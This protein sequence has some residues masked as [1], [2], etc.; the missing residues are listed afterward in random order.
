MFLLLFATLLLP[1][2]VSATDISSCWQ[3]NESGEYALTQNISGAI[4]ATASLV[5]SACIVIASDDIT[6]DCNGFSITN[7]GTED[8]AGILVN[9]STTIHY[10][11]VTIQNCPS[12]SQYE[13]G[14]YLYRTTQNI[15]RNTTT[16]NNTEYG[17]QLYSST[18]SNLTNNTEYN[19]SR[20]IYLFSSDNNAITGNTE[21]N[22]S[23][24][25]YLYSGSSNTLTNNSAYNNSN[26]GIYLYIS[27]SNNLT[28]NTAY[29]NPKGVYLLN[30]KG[31][32][33]TNCTLYSNQYGL[34][35][36]NSNYTMETTLFLPSGGEMENY[37]NLS[38]TDI[39]EAGE[40]YSINWS[41]S[42]ETFPTD[43]NPFENKYLNITTVAGTP[44]INSIIW[45]WGESE[46]SGYNESGFQLWKYNESGWTLINGTPDTDANELTIYAMG[47]ASIY[48]IFQSDTTPPDIYLETPEEGYTSNSSSINFTFKATDTIDASFNC[49]LYIDSE[50][51]QSNSSTLNN[52][53]TTFALSSIGDGAHNWSITCLD[54]N[55]NSNSS[56]TRNFTVDTIPPTVSLSSP[57][58]I[59]YATNNFTVNYT[60]D[61]TACSMFLDGTFNESLAICENTTLSN[62]SEGQHYVT[63]YANDS[64]NNTGSDEVYF[65]V[66]LTAPSITLVSPANITYATN[67]ISVNYTTNGVSCSM[68]LDGIFNTTLSSCENTT[69]SNLTDGQ[70]Y[71]TIYAND[72]VNNTGSDEVYF[73]VD[74]IAP[75]VSIDYPEGGRIYASGTLA[76]NY[77]TDGSYCSMSINDV[78]IQFLPDCENVTSYVFADG[79]SCLVIEAN[80]SANNTKTAE[81]CI[82]VETGY[83]EGEGGGGGG[84]GG[85]TPIEEEEIIDLEPEPIELPK[86]GEYDLDL[87]FA[88]FDAWMREKEDGGISNGWIFIGF[89]GIVTW[90]NNP[91]EK[92]KGNA[93]GA[94][95]LVITIAV[96]AAYWGA[97]W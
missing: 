60:T 52:T 58:N 67:N 82:I 90:L 95:M 94:T 92:K 43:H 89:L 62:L 54:N 56:E 12:V 73:I 3:I 25:I 88:D 15:V 13:T 18:Y 64:V 41:E 42:P 77:V 61:G 26:H 8:A 19:N 24:G 75:T 44:S 51:N 6:F 33:I 30:S 14:V 66:D 7:N 96:L 70:H 36:E 97:L 81:R 35:A 1:S 38:I 78:F 71:V 4:P 34:Y 39:Q 37:T 31:N 69:L 29:G 55:N 27:N 86:L 11:N 83:R 10:S 76:I 53:L 85:G 2:L 48:G 17:V 91:L 16:H 65:I 87:L 93:L 57:A 5:T 46:L 23:R 9:G 32:S 84:G 20:G 47:P 72:S 68:F 79:G 45:H 74:T 59:T 21:Y 40:E 63:I 28:S 49:S 50:Y 80:D 22:N